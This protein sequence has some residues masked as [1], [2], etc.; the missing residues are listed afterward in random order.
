MEGK[1]IV[2]IT[3][4]SHPDNHSS[5]SRSTPPHCRKSKASKHQKI[6]SC[7]ESRQGGNLSTYGTEK[8]EIIG[9]NASMLYKL[10]AQKSEKYQ[11][12]VDKI[13]NCDVTLGLADLGGNQ[14][15]SPENAIYELIIQNEKTEDLPLFIDVRKGEICS[16]DSFSAFMYHVDA[17]G[18]RNLDIRSEYSTM[19]MET[20]ISSKI[21]NMIK[22]DVR[23]EF[24]F[25]IE[26]C[27]LVGNICV[28]FT[29]SYGIG[30]YNK[31]KNILSNKP[32]H[33]G[34]PDSFE[35]KFKQF[36]TKYDESVRNFQKQ[37]DEESNS[38]KIIQNKLDKKRLDYNYKRIFGLH[39]DQPVTVN[40]IR[41][42]FYGRNGTRWLRLKIRYPGFGYTGS[43]TPEEL[44]TKETDMVETEIKRVNNGALNGVT[45]DFN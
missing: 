17:T 32:L 43:E 2:V 45:I 24:E 9:T 37:I 28:M 3:R 6:S 27:G 1:D 16:Y 35:D 29:A 13:Y 36:K 30:Y 11:K 12:L 15:Q 40:D 31:I 14:N 21:M 18:N 42:T 38:F 23:K 44:L 25:E 39:D 20:L 10:V 41:F 4:D 26:V 8:E 34:F 22:K 19:L 33:G 5:F 7:A